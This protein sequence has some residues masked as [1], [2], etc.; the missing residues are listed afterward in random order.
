RVMGMRGVCG[1]TN[2]REA[3]AV[4]AYARG[5]DGSVA[6]VGT[7]ATG[8]RGSGAPHLPSQGSVVVAGDRLLVANAGSDDVS[9]FAV[10]ETPRLV[11]RTPSGGGA[12]RSIAVRD[13]LVYVLNTGEPAVAGFRRTGDTLSSL[14][15]ARAAGTDP[16]PGP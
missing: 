16:A 13:D 4:V 5:D 7:F 8:G 12:P 3:R 6:T 14:G 10:G 11:S 15:V 9:M 1:Q 2:D